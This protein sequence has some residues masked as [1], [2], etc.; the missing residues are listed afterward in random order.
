MSLCAVGCSLSPTLSLSLKMGIHLLVF[1]FVRYASYQFST[2]V[3]GGTHLDAPC[4]FY[5]NSWTV[6][7]IPA[8]RLIGPAVVVDITL[9]AQDDPDTLLNIS[10]LQAWENDNGQIPDGAIV[11][12]NWRVGQT[13]LLSLAMPLKT[14][15]TCTSLDLTQTLW[16]GS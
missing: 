4:H 8:E 11:F 14:P 3:H 2:S 7:D 12:M 10:D 16:T 9:R 6:N 5:E 15:T 13:K 1:I